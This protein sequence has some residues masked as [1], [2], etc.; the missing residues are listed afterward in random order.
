MIRR[1]RRKLKELIRLS[2]ILLLVSGSLCLGGC[3]SAELIIAGIDAAITVANTYVIQTQEPVVVKSAECS[4][5][6]EPV[7]PDENF[8]TRWTEAE[9]IQA[10]DL[11]IRLR[12]L[13]NE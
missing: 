6:I 10:S 12:E 7:T 2:K 5:K 8:E 11:A 13:C 1:L 3:A 9:I 4:G